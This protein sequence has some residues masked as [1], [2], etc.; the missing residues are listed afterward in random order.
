MDVEERLSAVD[1]ANEVFRF[2][3]IRA[4]N[5]YGEPAGNYF[6]IPLMRDF[7]VEINDIKTKISREE[8]D[9]ATTILNGAGR[10]QRIARAVPYSQ[11]HK[12]VKAF[13]ES[14]NYTIDDVVVVGVDRGGRLPSFLIREALGKDKGYTLKVDQAFDNSGSL[15]SAKLEELIEKG[16]LKDRFVL[17]VDS[18]VDSG[19]QIKVLQKYFDSDEWKAKIGHKAWG[20]VGSNE[21]GH[22]MDNHKNINWGLNPDESFEDKPELMG[23]DYAPGSNTTVVDKPTAL[24]EAIKNTLLEV[25]RGVILDMSNLPNLLINLKRIKSSYAYTGRI[26]KSKSWQESPDAAK[27]LKAPATYD[28]LD[29]YAPGLPR[30]RLLVIGDGENLTLKDQEAEYIARSLA[31]CYDVIAGTAD[32]NPGKVLDMFSNHWNKSAQLYQ[33]SPTGRINRDNYLDMPIHYSGQTK[34]EFRENMV[35][36]ADAVLVLGG[37]SGTLT[38]TMLSLYAGKQVYALSDFGTL[39]HFLKKSYGMKE[40]PNLHLVDTLPEAIDALKKLYKE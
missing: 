29:T 20:I 4:E 21:N 27:D 13:V 16:V 6:K 8:Y 3:Y 33:Q 30:K 10:F 31:Q 36:N 32:G 2:A 7:N 18:T 9:K 22:D 5:G 19:R 35:Q 25:P 11:L 40:H 23:V 17:F 38:E 24:S 34:E 28:T 15:D 12:D 26:L 14:K 1:N 37:N 39:G